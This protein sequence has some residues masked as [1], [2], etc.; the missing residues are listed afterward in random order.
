MFSGLADGSKKAST[1]MLGFFAGIAEKIQQKLFDTA[2]DR[3]TSGLF[4]VFQFHSGGFVSNYANGGKAGGDIPA[5]LTAGEYV[6]RKKVV[7]RVGTGALDKMNNEGS[8]D[9]LFN[10]PNRDNFDLLGDGSNGGSMVTQNFDSGGLV[11]LLKLN[12]GGL[13][14][15]DE[16]DKKSAISDI[17]YGVGVGAGAAYAG[18]KNRD[19]GNDDDAPTAP[20]TKGVNTSSA[21]N[22]GFADPRL[23]GKYRQDNQNSQDQGKYLLDKYNYDVNKKN[24]KEREKAAMLS[25][26]IGTVGLGVGAA[27]GKK[28]GDSMADSIVA[29]RLSGGGVKSENGNV[30]SYSPGKGFSSDARGV[31]GKYVGDLND[32]FAGHRGA[33]E[34]VGQSAKGA[35]KFLREK[36]FLVGRTGNPLFA[37]PRPQEMVPGQNPAAKAS[38]CPGGVCPQS[39]GSKNSSSA[40]APK[41]SGKLQRVYDDLM[42]ARSSIESNQDGRGPALYQKDKTEYN[43]LVD[44][45]KKINSGFFGSL[46]HMNA[47]GQV[48]GP[49]GIDKVGPVMLDSGEYVIKSN[50]AKGIEKDFP[51]LLDKLNA[52]AGFA[53]GGSVGDQV[54][55]AS[56]SK[57]SNSTSNNVTV[58]ISV[59]ANGS[60]STQVQGQSENQNAEGLGS[61]LKE[62]VLG[63]IASE[64]RVGGMLS[65]H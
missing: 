7:D 38:S 15:L 1:V 48:T 64:K 27:V 31:G 65:G 41:S 37:A 34:D 43:R 62:A 63:V 60:A 4:K 39:Y 14:R 2:A 11:K 55:P 28:I 5:M 26:I 24:A 51:G 58:N 29:S 22:L 45:T 13:A 6:V 35:A 59:G 54:A 47:G 33:S 30:M 50:S 19:K 56:S 42:L 23:S 3:L 21:L 16:Y 10:E 17:T 49:A 52:G 8:L 44:K 61:R 18:Y 36:G 25:T 57:T 40:P 12:G 32:R 53:E 46:E 9:E 20:M